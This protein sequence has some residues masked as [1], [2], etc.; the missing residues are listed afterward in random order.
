MNLRFLQKKTFLLKAKVGKGKKLTSAEILYTI[1]G[2]QYWVVG[3]PAYVKARNPEC[4][5]ALL[6]H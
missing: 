1:S 4:C 6:S 2:G 3:R 5:A